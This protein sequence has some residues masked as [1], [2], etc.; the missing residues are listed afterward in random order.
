MR[1]CRRHFLCL[2]FEQTPCTQLQ[3]VLPEKPGLGLK[4]SRLATC[5]D[6]ASIVS[7]SHCGLRQES[8]RV[9]PISQRYCEGQVMTGELL[10]S[11]GPGVKSKDRE[12]KCEPAAV[13]HPVVHA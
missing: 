10:G 7:L 13:P 12:E 5:S 8:G 11:T 6:F 1:S 3:H 2:R 4:T 9:I